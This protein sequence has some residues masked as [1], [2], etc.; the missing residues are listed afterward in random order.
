MTD[1]MTTNEVS[2]RLGVGL[3]QVQRLAR[4]GRIPFVKNGRRIQVPRSAWDTFI[5]TQTE[6]ALA[7]IRSDKEGSHGEIAV[8]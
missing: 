1:Y 7:S 8:A 4:Q 2:L 5:A 6:A 3:R